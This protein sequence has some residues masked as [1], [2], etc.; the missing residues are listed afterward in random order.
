LK[1]EIIGKT[2][3]ELGRCEETTEQDTLRMTIPFSKGEVFDVEHLHRRKDGSNFWV[4]T[5]GQPILNTKG[6]VVQYFAM[7]EDISLS[8]KYEESLQ[9]EKGKYQSIIANRNLG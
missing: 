6:E 4:K 5:K 7:I 8:K 2:P 9:V 1:E 3:I